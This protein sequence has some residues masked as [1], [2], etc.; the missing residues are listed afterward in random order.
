MNEINI[1]KHLRKM[2]WV[3]ISLRDLST[4]SSKLTEIQM[5]ATIWAKFLKMRNLWKFSAW[6][7]RSR[8]FQNRFT[9][10]LKNTKSMKYKI[11]EVRLSIKKT[12]F[13]MKY[14]WDLKLLKQFQKMKPAK[15]YKILKKEK[16]MSNFEKW[17]FL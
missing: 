8:I 12:Y 6:T 7:K 13:Q 14:H 17:N 5:I 1:M 15:K 16:N 11:K 10:I 3:L 4:Y 9:I 2:R